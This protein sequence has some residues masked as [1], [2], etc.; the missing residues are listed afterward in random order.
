MLNFL[1][2]QLSGAW[3]E[4]SMNQIG[5]QILSS[6]TALTYLAWIILTNTILYLIVNA[7]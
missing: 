1:V 6:R 2:S 3:K 4:Y 5:I 7:D